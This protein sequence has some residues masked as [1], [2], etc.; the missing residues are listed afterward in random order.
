VWVNGLSH[1]HFKLRDNPLYE[2]GRSLQMIDLSAIGQEYTR[3]H[4]AVHL[5]FSIVGRHICSHDHRADVQEPQHLRVDRDRMISST[6]SLRLVNEIA[7][8]RRLLGDGAD[9]VLEDVALARATAAML[10]RGSVD[11]WGKPRNGLPQRGSLGPDSAEEVQPRSYGG[12]S[13]SGISGLT[14]PRSI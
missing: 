11:R 12:W 3:G 4:A 7:G 2:H 6:S 9:G 8:L 14:D 10:A 1:E 5:H 13:P